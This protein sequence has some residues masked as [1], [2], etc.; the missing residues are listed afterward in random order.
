VIFASDEPNGYDFEGSSNRLRNQLPQAVNSIMINRTA[1]DSRTKL[2]AEIN[3]GRFFVNYSGHGTA[4]AWVNDGFLGKVDFTGNQTSNPPKLPAINNTNLTIFTMLTCLNGY[5]ISADP[6]AA[7]DGLAE[8]MLKESNGAVASWA[9]SGLTTP[10]IQEVMA[11]RFYS[12]LGA[13]NFNRLG[14]L[15]KD[16]KTSVSGGR[17]VRLSWVLLG[18]PTLRV[19]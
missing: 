4:S 12:Q 5:F 16:S 15:I 1:A 9:S 17:D 19:K 3:N 18:D 14:D 2:L 13:G 7:S 11:M 10:D 6:T 8:A